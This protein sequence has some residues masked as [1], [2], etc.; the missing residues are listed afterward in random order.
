MFLRS[1]SFL[2]KYIYQNYQ[3]IRQIQRD[4]RLKE[5]IDDEKKKKINFSAIINISILTLLTISVLII[6]NSDYI[7]IWNNPLFLIL[8]S[9]L[10]NI[11]LIIIL[12]VAFYVNKSKEINSFRKYHAAEHMLLNMYQS[13][14]KINKKILPQFSR[15]IW[16]CNS[17]LF[18][19]FSAL[20]II[21]NSILIHVLPP[22]IYLIV[23]I[24]AILIIFSLS[25]E[26]NFWFLRN[27]K[28]KYLRYLYQKIN[29]T[30]YILTQQPEENNTKTGLLALRNL[31]KKTKPQ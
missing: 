15:I 10:E 30:Q 3:I 23:F 22:F 2:Y 20:L 6:F 31:L 7:S 19:I 28:N 9:I 27:L 26:L 12:L 8:G 21:I 29:T 1:V 11:F 13:T 24:P 14:G 16:A 18:L 4:L 25:Y 17:N 5:I